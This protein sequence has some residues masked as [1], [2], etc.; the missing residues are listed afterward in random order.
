MLPGNFFGNNKPICPSNKPQMP[1]VSQMGTMK[2]YF[3]FL[4]TF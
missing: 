4:A 2:M 1:T 3:N